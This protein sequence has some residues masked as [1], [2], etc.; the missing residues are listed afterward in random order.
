M[1]AM[2]L[3]STTAVIVLISGGI[4]MG[5]E[6]MDTAPAK[7]PVAQPQAPAETT[8]SPITQG[9]RDAPET[10][11]QGASAGLAKLS[12][13]QRIKIDTII[14]QQKMAPANLNVSTVVGTIVPPDVRLYPLPV[15]AINIYPEW[16]GHEYVVVG[17]KILVVEPRRHAIVAII[18]T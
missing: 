7:A 1:T 18:G 15:E 5:Q 13:E 2:R 3:L 9:G 16:H 14:R 8:A 17:D 11:G 6:K 4:T 10:T 12:T